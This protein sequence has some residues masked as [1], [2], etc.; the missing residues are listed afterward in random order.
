[1]PFLHLQRDSDLVKINVSTAVRGDVVCECVHVDE[2]WSC[3]QM[4]FRV[5][6]N[7]NY[8]RSNMLMLSRDQ[9]DVLWHARECFPQDFRAEVRG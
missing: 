6:F 7:T 5:A 8:V 2:A 9:V 3:E 1:M 4:L